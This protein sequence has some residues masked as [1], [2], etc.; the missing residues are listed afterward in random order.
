VQ[1][2]ATLVA[3]SAVLPLNAALTGAALLRPRPRV[4]AR[5]AAGPRRTVL[6]SGGK[7]TKAL[8]LARSF[9]AAGHRVVLVETARYRLTGHRFSRAV[10]AFHVVPQPD[11]PRYADELLRVVRAEGVDVY[12]PVC[13]PKASRY[14][15][16]ARATLDPHCEVVHADPDTLDTLDDKGRFAAA[17]AALGLPV[18]DTHRITDPRQVEEFAFPDDGTVYVLKSIAYD[19]VRR[20]DLTPL[21]RPTPEETAAFAR[22]LPISEENPWI[23]Q[24][25]V[26]GEEFCTHSTVRDGVVRLHCCCR[27]SAFQLNYE[28]VEDPEIEDWVRRFV[29]AL[30]VTGQASF[31]FIRGADGV[32]RAIEC[33]PRTHSAITMFYDHPGVA[34]AYLE[35]QG[36][37]V[38]PTA[39]SR[40][41]Y[42]LYHELWQA[43]RHPGSVASRLR[44]IAR[45]KDAILDGRDPLPFLLVHHLQI[46]RLVLGNL[47]RAKPWVK[48]DFNIGKLV[49]D[50]GD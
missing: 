15:A 47:L 5:P 12:V 42:W 31:D 26:P 37:E 7:M 40:P 46:P 33:N 50:A 34:A 23:L 27:S 24:E 48:I 14:D 11:D 4:P 20:M 18:P 35:D 21:P 19:P 30:G 43:L 45:G 36:P 44:T 29:G 38:R 49:E 2:A 8:Q 1:S 13:S 16:L 3:L 41:T 22:A 10:D 17:A 32:A 9:H 39:A 6:I 28:H 25:F